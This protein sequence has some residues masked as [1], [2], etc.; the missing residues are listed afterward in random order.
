[1][2]S[3]IHKIK[4]LYLLNDLKR[5]GLERR[6]IELIAN[7]PEDEFEYKVFLLNGEIQYDLEKSIQDRITLTKRETGLLAKL[8]LVFKLYHAF[9]P[10]VVHAWSVITV[11]I[12]FFCQIGGTSKIIN[13]AVASAPTRLN[14]IGLAYTLMRIGF[15]VSDLIIANSRAGLNV[16]SPPEHKSIVIHNGLSLKRFDNFEVDRNYRA[17]VGIN[18]EYSIVMVAS[19][20][21]EKDHFSLVKVAEKIE[22]LRDDVTFVCVGDGDQLANIAEMVNRLGLRNFVILGMRN[23]VEKIVKQCDIGMLLSTNGE[24]LSNA[25]L[26]YMA[27]EKP[28][29]ANQSGGNSELILHGENGFLVTENIVA[30]TVKGITMI[31]QDPLIRIK[32]GHN[33]RRRIEEYFLIESMVQKYITTYKNY[34]G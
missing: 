8:S 1:M 24:G 9:R 7:L 23:D 2:H 11:L 14:K 13:S 12:A 3:E 22:S 19:F 30:D 20:T 21:R 28:V 10:D 26:E 6:F 5:G 18:T 29:I 34:A 27:L 32:M 4:V 16:Y 25:I 15:M 31:L 33:S 17:L